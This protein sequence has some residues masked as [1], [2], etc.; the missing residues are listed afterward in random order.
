MLNEFSEKL[1]EFNIRGIIYRTAY[2]NGKITAVG[3]DNRYDV[4]IGS[5]G[6]SRKNVPVNDINI[7][8]AIGD[9]VGVGY[10][11][12][13]RERPIIIGK[14][15]SITITEVGSSVNSLG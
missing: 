1:K 10:E 8:Y 3:T 4:E 9:T 6:K 13:N 12:D 2:V 5:S 14:L 7:T 15:R 11:D